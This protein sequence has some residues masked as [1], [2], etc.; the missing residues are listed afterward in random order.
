M[1]GLVAGRPSV[2][3]LRFRRRKGRCETSGDRI[4]W[5]GRRPKMTLRF[6]VGVFPLGKVV[7]RRG[8]QESGSQ[9][10]SWPGRDLGELG[11][12]RSVPSD[13]ALGL[14]SSA[15]ERVREVEAEEVGAGP[16]GN[17]NHPR[18]GSVAAPRQVAN[19]GA[20]RAPDHHFLPCLGEGSDRDSAPLSASLF[21][22][23][24][25]QFSTVY[26]CCPLRR[27][28]PPPSWGWRCRG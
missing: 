25:S 14:P 5:L 24:D 28:C 11:G 9:R 3:L 21:A 10:S 18:A 15:E 23:S 2:R 20:V 16:T 4:G 17:R 13:S 27:C 26:S 12:G 8:R 19:P 7:W 1:T 22:P 6:Q